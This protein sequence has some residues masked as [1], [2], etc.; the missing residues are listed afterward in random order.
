MPP[1]PERGAPTAITRKDLKAVRVPAPL[2]EADSYED[3][4]VTQ[5]GAPPGTQAS[6]QCVVL[7]RLDGV[8][9]GSLISLGAE[10]CAIG[11]HHSNQVQLHEDGVSRFHAQIT[12]T[13]QAHVIEDLASSNGTWVRGR[14]VTRAALCDGDLMQFGAQACFRFTVTDGVH[15]RLLRQM[16]QSSTRDALTGAY[17]RRHFDERL[18]AELAYAVRHHTELGLVMFDIDH[19]KRVNDTLGHPAGDAVI[20]HIAAVV[21][22]QLRGEDTLARYGGEEF[23][24]LLRATT[25]KDTVR[26]AERIR[27][28]VDVLPAR[29]ERRLI[30]VSVSAGC[31]SLS[32]CDESTGAEMLKRADERLYAA[33]RA[34]RNRVVGAATEG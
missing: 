18:H 23:V 21:A 24:V 34:G 3:D 7:V 5:V 26:V 13:G 1:P 17:N 2:L 31:A 28:R 33:K 16:H 4:R 29:V 20:R 32:E 10:R 25:A 14:R 9:A 12:W 30:P 27:S 15:E 19:F 11:R 6:N 22:A 8:E